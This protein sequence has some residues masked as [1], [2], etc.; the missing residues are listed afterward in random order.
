MDLKDINNKS[1]LKSAIDT[2]TLDFNSLLTTML[3]RDEDYKKAAL[4]Y[5]WLRDYKNLLKNEKTFSSMYL[6]VYKRR[7]IVS[8]N[9]GFN[10]GAELG[11]KHYAVVLHDS[12]KNNPLITVLPLSSIKNKGQKDNIHPDNIN[13]G[14]EIYHRVESKLDT[15]YTS[16]KSESET[17]TK[18][19]KDLDETNP[20][21]A[22]VIEKKLAD[23]TTNMQRLSKTAEELRHLKIGSYGIINQIKTVSKMRVINPTNKYSSLYD[24][25]ISS[26]T[27]LRIDEKIS[28]YYTMS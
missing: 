14:R 7:N 28:K 19:E 17:L 11:G 9:F 21:I 26:E 25:K 27:M 22:A 12:G 2:L 18:I 13:L 5:Y 4:I 24:L 8:I 6:P 15:L 23:L 10:P 20:A 3:K 1:N 16:I